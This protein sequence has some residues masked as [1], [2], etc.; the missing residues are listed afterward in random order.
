ML[1]PLEW[2]SILDNLSSGNTIICLGAELFTA[3][4]VDIDGAL[5]AEL[6]GLDNA[7]MYTDGLFHF[8]GAGDMTS[9]TKIKQFYGRDFPAINKITEQLAQLPVPVFLSTSPDHQLE[10]AFARLKRPYQYDFHY[11]NRPAR[12][13]TDPSAQQPLIY[14]L[15][16]DINRRESLVLTHE[17][18]F[19][20]MESLVEGKSVS[21]VVK[22]RLQAAYNFIFLGLPFGKWY[23]KVLLHFLQKDTDRRAVK[24]A[25]NHAFDTEIQSFIIDQFQ[26]TCVPTDIGAF[27]DELYIR[28]TRSDY[29]DQRDKALAGDSWYKKWTVLV[30]N[31]KIEE[32]LEEMLALLPA[33]LEQNPDGQ[34]QLFNFS[35]RLANLNKSLGKGIVS[36]ENAQLQRNQ[37]RDGLLSYLHDLIKPLAL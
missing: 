8:R 33:H 36:Q 27:V 11:P 35:G 30:G 4:G 29:Y 25:A 3:A 19:A 2:N 21:R 23:M 31:D 12:E 13:L 34:N 14:N 24:Y 6:H 10:R 18:L 22:A 5:A 28:W 15:L 17:D 7:H 16:G 26:F 37:L 9:Y 1:Q 20:F 32:V